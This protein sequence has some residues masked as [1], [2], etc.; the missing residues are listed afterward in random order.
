[1]QA[2]TG[3]TKMPAIFAG[4]FLLPLNARDDGGHFFLPM[5]ACCR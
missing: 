1:M 2:D 4:I 3:P 5:N